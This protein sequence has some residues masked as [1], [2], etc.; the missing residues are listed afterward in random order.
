MVPAPTTPAGTSAAMPL[1]ADGEAAVRSVTSIAGRPPA[2][3]ARAS[4]TAVS[5]S[6]MVRT[7]TTGPRARISEMVFIVINAL[8]C[9]IEDRS[10]FLGAADQGAEGAEQV[11]AGAEAIAGQVGG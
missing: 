3:S 4:G 5:R 9:C 2:A 7:G 10:A 1:M 8:C 6:S 11:A